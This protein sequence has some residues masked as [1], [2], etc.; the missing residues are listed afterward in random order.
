MPKFKKIPVSNFFVPLKYGEDFE[1]FKRKNGKRVEF[2]TKA[3]VVKFC[4][5]NR[6]H[7]MHQSYQLNKLITIK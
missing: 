6:C 4:I 2:R 5:E 1:E 7:Y 3:A